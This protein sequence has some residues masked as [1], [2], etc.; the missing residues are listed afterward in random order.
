MKKSDSPKYPSLREELWRLLSNLGFDSQQQ[1]ADFISERHEGAPNPQTVERWI[2]GLQRPGKLDLFYR[3]LKETVTSRTRSAKADIS[4][5]QG[6][7]A[8]QRIRGVITAYL[9]RGWP[10]YEF[11]PEDEALWTKHYDQVSVSAEE[12][13]G[14]ESSDA[15]K[16]F[17]HL[18]WL[19]IA[20]FKSGV[21]SGGSNPFDERFQTTFE[22]RH[23]FAI[24]SVQ[25]QLIERVSASG[26]RPVAFLNGESGSG[27]STI[28]RLAMMHLIENGNSHILHADFRDGESFQELVDK[29]SKTPELPEDTIVFVDGFDVSSVGKKGRSPTELFNLVVK[30][31]KFALVVCPQRIPGDGVGDQLVGSFEKAVGVAEFSDYVLLDADNY[32][33][34]KDALVEQYLL[35]HPDGANT[36][37]VSR[38]IDQEVAL[39]YIG[40]LI[41][42]DDELDETLK[43]R[44]SKLS[45]ESRELL[46]AIT[47][48]TRK[49]TRLWYNDVVGLRE[50][51]NR[52][53]KLQREGL[54][55]LG[56]ERFAGVSE[57]YDQRIFEE[58]K[59][60]HSSDSRLSSKWIAASV[61]RH[62][63]RMNPILKRL[64]RRKDD[65][66]K[67]YQIELLSQ[68]DVVLEKSNVHDLLDLKN[69][70]YTTRVLS[71]EERRKCYARLM[72]RLSETRIENRNALKTLERLWSES[73][74]DLLELEVE[75]RWDA[76]DSDDAKYYYPKELMRPMGGL[77]KSYSF[78]NVELLLA[79]YDQNWNTVAGVLATSTRTEFQYWERDECRDYKLS[80]WAERKLETI[81]VDLYSRYEALSPIEYKVFAVLFGCFASYASPLAISRFDL[82]RIMARQAVAYNYNFY[83]YQ[84]LFLT[85]VR[86]HAFSVDAAAI[87]VADS[88]LPFSADPN[89][90]HFWFGHFEIPPSLLDRLI[91]VVSDPRNKRTDTSVLPL[92]WVDPEQLGKLVARERQITP[93]LESAVLAAYQQARQSRARME[94]DGDD[95]VM[96]P[97]ALMAGN[98]RTYSPLGQVLRKDGSNTPRL[99]G[100]NRRNTIAAYLRETSNYSIACSYITLFLILDEVR[101]KLI[102]DN[103]SVDKYEAFVSVDPRRVVDRLYGMY[104]PFLLNRDLQ[105]YIKYCAERRT[106][107]A[108]FDFIDSPIEYERYRTRAL[109]WFTVVQRLHQSGRFNNL[110]G[111]T[112]ANVLSHLDSVRY[113]DEIERLFWEDFSTAYPAW[114]KQKSVL[115]LASFQV[116]AGRNRDARATIK[117]GFSFERYKIQNYR[118]VAF[119]VE[120]LG[121]AGVT[122]AKDIPEFVHPFHI[123]R[124]VRR[125]ATEVFRQAVRRVSQGQRAFGERKLNEELRAWPQLL[126]QFPSAADLFAGMSSTWDIEE[127]DKIIVR[128]FYIDGRKENWDVVNEAR[129]S[130]DAGRLEDAGNCLGSYF[131][132]SNVVL[133][134]PL[135]LREAL[136]MLG[137]IKRRSGKPAPAIHKQHMWS[138]SERIT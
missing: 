127:H 112:V 72:D 78:I 24:R 106:T 38:Q 63:S 130:L 132:D 138:M 120:I 2:G 95:T 41:S 16:E 32:Q 103:L 73:K 42:F 46:A 4:A 119:A 113:A 67:W 134:D 56:L 100:R 137:N 96:K 85:L 135:S 8:I 53:I 33:A 136:R 45:A 49:G 39:P 23:L 36:D 44:L 90:L 20:F 3:A 5:D 99:A 70:I 9:K 76:P 34:D 30:E 108:S 97:R 13:G 129:S 6:R 86:R 26:P 107:G 117:K 14:V 50:P 110:S 109:T 94:K 12:K 59:V 79:D 65:T 19:D 123:A 48:F 22:N 21:D 133:W 82:S 80:V 114:R 58:L 17:G 87:A 29:L 122:Y 55:Q 31:N 47:F 69:L 68:L 102:D 116:R 77:S 89:L 37:A 28:L 111:N 35:N 15:L 43:S 91:E 124:F 61:V 1:A 74:G 52:L 27:K 18:P 101:D 105:A 57:F 83:H 92:F 93:L 128:Q 104:K 75:G 98:I 66:A 126:V 54:I 60:S 84:W 51:D 11:L 118:Y 125:H 64:R 7:S 25:S 40:A 131:G 121:R 10:V 88:R 71:E 62:F 81:I 115:D